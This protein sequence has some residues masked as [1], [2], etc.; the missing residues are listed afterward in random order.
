MIPQRKTKPKESRS[1]IYNGLQTIVTLTVGSGYR[2]SVVLDGHS[3]GEEC[4]LQFRG[5]VRAGV[6]LAREFDASTNRIRWSERLRIRLSLG[7]RKMGTSP[8]ERA[9]CTGN[10]VSM[11]FRDLSDVRVRRAK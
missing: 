7:S 4:A 6:R 5:K 3:S 8:L 2:G 10:E 1:F 11:Y 9:S